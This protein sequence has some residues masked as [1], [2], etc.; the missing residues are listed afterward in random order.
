MSRKP[1]I[2][3]MNAENGCFVVRWG[4]GRAQKSELTKTY[5]DALTLARKHFDAAGGTGS[6]E[7][8]DYTGTPPGKVLRLFTEE[9]GGAA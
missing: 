1:A 7:A 5:S 9:T 8:F 3:I 2:R 6:A 4:E